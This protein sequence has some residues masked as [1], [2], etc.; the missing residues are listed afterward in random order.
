MNFFLEQSLIYYCR[1][2]SL[3]CCRCG[4]WWSERVNVCVVVESSEEH[5][6]GLNFGVAGL[7]SKSVMDDLHLF[8]YIYFTSPFSELNLFTFNALDIRQTPR[9]DCARWTHRAWLFI[10]NMNSWI[11]NCLLSLV[12]MRAMK[13]QLDQLLSFHT[14]LPSSSSHQFAADQLW[15]LC[16]RLSVNRIE[17]WTKTQTIYHTDKPRA[18][19]AKG[20]EQSPI[21]FRFRIGEQIQMSTHFIMTFELVRNWN[22]MSESGCVCIC[23]GGWLNQVFLLILNG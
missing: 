15:G 2:S 16:S 1:S 10:V 19:T 11:G 4:R 8:L 17:S 9:T 12:C 23:M 5:I 18:F 3:S 21:S 6:N 22:G 14:S 7:S 20:D 13:S